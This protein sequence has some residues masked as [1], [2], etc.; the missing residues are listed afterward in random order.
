MRAGL[1]CGGIF[2]LCSHPRPIRPRVSFND[3][4]VPV[5]AIERLASSQVATSVQEYESSD[6]LDHRS[7]AETSNSVLKKA[8][9]SR[10]SLQT[11]AAEDNNDVVASQ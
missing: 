9:R 10:R 8:Q 5:S 4:I 6:K 2:P 11:P 1:T 3:L 7:V